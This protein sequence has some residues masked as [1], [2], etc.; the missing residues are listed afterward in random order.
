MQRIVL[1]LLLFPLPILAYQE[2]DWSA[3]ENYLE[4]VFS[5]SEV[6][7]AMDILE[8]YIR[9]PLLLQFAKPQDLTA[10]P[11]IDIVTAQIIINR[12]KADP[13]ISYYALLDSLSISEVQK[14]IIYFTT[15]LDK[16]PKELKSN[17]FL[18]LSVRTNHRLEKVRG[19]SEKKYLGDE[20]DVYQRI[21]ANYD[22]FELS[23]FANKDL[24]E[25]HLAEFYSGSAKYSARNFKLTMGDY[26][27]NSG[28]GNI[29][30]QVF[31]MGKGS[32][33]VSSA[34]SYSN[35]AKIN[36]STIGLSFFRG[37]AAEYSGQLSENIDMT[38]I[39]FYSNIDRPATIDEENTIATSLYTAGYFRTST[40]M[41]K[42]DALNEQAFGTVAEVKL[43][44]FSVG[45][46]ALNM[47]YSL[48]VESTSG[49]VFRGKEGTL[50]SIFGNYCL[51]D[52]IF[53][54]EVTRDNNAETAYKFVGMFKSES[55]SATVL[56]RN[57]SAKFRSPFGTNFGEFSNPAN[58][59]GLYAGI[60]YY[61][62]K[63]LNLEGY[64]DIYKS[65]TRTYTVQAPIRGLDL[66]GRIFFNNLA[67]G[68]L[69]AK[70]KYESKTDG[71]K[72]AGA[73]GQ[74]IFDLT[75]AEARAE[76]KSAIR[77]NLSLRLRL[78]AVLVDYADVK[79]T[80]TGF[81]GFVELNW[82]VIG[83]LRIKGRIALFSTES[84]NSAIWHF[85]YRMPGSA[86]AAA[87]FESGNRAILSI[88]YKPFDALTFYLA[89]TRL[90]K[91]NSSTL[92]SSYDL[93]QGNVDNRI[94]TMISVKL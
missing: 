57:Y 68:D 8:Y 66:Q 71:Y 56:Y 30:G 15:S 72:V 81:A 34:F 17:N 3:M 70:V 80:E 92:G 69:A 12:I 91:Y 38:I 25:P 41:S 37:A 78:D 46:T 6:S 49:A 28:F 1:I 50:F 39:P 33:F 51:S 48:P 11:T 55:Y 24:G 67:I 19:I 79:P 65:H 5:E 31:S 77:K 21:H 23:L 7:P 53:G 54:G 43:N 89:Y 10:I 32:D 47:N 88:D 40:E 14:Q 2:P 62:T 29:F 52:I 76:L 75:R 26:S 36:S 35:N 22:K 94:Y 84:Y 13:D 83:S 18:N 16:T 93:I 73:S 9:K 27:I 86:A 82:N 45:F 61:L 64:L 85:E 63:D 90:E 59:E 87:L 4:S 58:E 74:T 20:W 42:K 60:S 44:D